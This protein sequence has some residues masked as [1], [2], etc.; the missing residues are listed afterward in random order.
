MYTNSFYETRHNETH[1]SAEKLMSLLITRYPDTKSAIDVGCGVGTFLAALSK[2]GVS[3]ILGVDG[4]WVNQDLL[5]I[6]KTSFQNIDL[7]APGPINRKFD[8]AITLE[9][10]EH[11]P[12]ESAENFIKW[13]CTLSDKIMFSA[14]IPGQGG[15]FHFNE[16]WP[17]YWIDIF[18]RNGFMH[19]DCIRPLIWDDQDIFFWY[20]QNTFLFEKTTQ[21]LQSELLQVNLV[22]PELFALYVNKPAPLS[23]FQRLKKRF[24]K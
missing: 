10:A 24:L 4:K 3:D 18:K 2:K 19:I 6:D 16:A 17:S 11:L 1:Y 9:V 20:R 21:S 8:I 7:T 12:A 22:H 14:A 13:L 15:E 5:A 23:F